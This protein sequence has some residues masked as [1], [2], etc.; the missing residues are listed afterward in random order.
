MRAAAA[1]VIVEATVVTAAIFDT[2]LP[3]TKPAITKDPWTCTTE[4]LQK[5]FMPPKP[6]GLLLD[7]LVSYGE[8]LKKDCKP[9]LTDAMGNPECEFP[10]HSKWCAFAAAVPSVLVSEYSSYGSAA[11]SW[12]SESSSEAVEFATYCPNR[13]FTAMTA[14]R[15]R[16]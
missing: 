1:I 6:T 7:A 8:D 14:Q 16:Q 2:I 12:W 5:Y 4:P 10:A 9:T 11:S 13:W 15:P 3:T